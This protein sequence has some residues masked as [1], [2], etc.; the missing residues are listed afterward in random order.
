MTFTR[1]SKKTIP[2]VATV[3]L[4]REAKTGN[5]A[6]KKNTSYRVTASSIGTPTVL[7]YWRWD[8]SENTTWEQVTKP[9]SNTSS[10]MILEPNHYVDEVRLTTKGATMTTQVIQPGVG[11]L[12]TADARGTT[13]PIQLQQF[14]ECWN[15]SRKK[16]G[17][18]RDIPI[19]RGLF[20]Y[21][22]SAQVANNS[23]GQG[24]ASVNLTQ[25][26]PGG[27]V[28]L[29]QPPKRVTNSLNGSSAMGQLLH[30]P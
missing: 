11:T 4:G 23:L 9:A 18:S 13:H 2:L 22:A 20:F 26:S 28:R 15:P 21:N 19:A 7:S 27:S 24:R 30:K 5:Y 25:V 17:S 10:Y 6:L 14:W 12:S 16:A 29:P 8:G 3:F 1:V